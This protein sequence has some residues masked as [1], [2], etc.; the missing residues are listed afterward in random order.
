MTIGSFFYALS[1]IYAKRYI[2]PKKIDSSALTSY[3][4]FFS[5]IIVTLLIDH[6]TLFNVTQSPKALIGS[7]VGLGFIGTGIAYIIYYKLI[8]GLGAVRASTVTYIPP[9]VALIVGQ[10]IGGEALNMSSIVGVI[11]ILLGVFI[12][13]KSRV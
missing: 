8:E 4:T 3:Q 1:F 6:T 5:L 12:T 9:I 13:K 11:I 2:I 10:T 7:V